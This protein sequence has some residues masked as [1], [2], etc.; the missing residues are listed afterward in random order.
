MLGIGKRIAKWVLHKS[1]DEL[2]EYLEE[3]FYDDLEDRVID[4]TL[5]NGLESAERELLVD[6]VEY[7]EKKSF[8]NRILVRIE[9]WLEEW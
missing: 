3:Q 5:D 4:Y 2:Q 1:I 9:Y 8:V 6:Y 7:L